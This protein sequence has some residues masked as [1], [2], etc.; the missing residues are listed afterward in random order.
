[1]ISRAMDG[2]H[3][4]AYAISGIKRGDTISLQPYP[5]P[6]P[7]KIDRDANAKI[8][9][10]KAIVDAVRSL[11]GE[12]MLSPA[13]KVAALISSDLPAGTIEALVPYLSV[14]SRLADVS[15]VE[16][17]P[18]SLAPVAVVKS[19]RIMLDVEIDVDAERER[20][21]KERVRLDGE[22]GKAKAKLG[23]ESFVSR[24]P[25]DVVAQMRERVAGFESTLTK[26]IEQLR[27]LDGH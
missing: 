10:L 2:V 19:V 17:L 13:K 22:I 1:M 18:R 16:T 23:N 14:L 5:Q 25:A 11:R 3:A 20:L 12:M 8:D 27:K 21:G 9:T 26:V 4:S 15:V 7:E 24:A 6:Q